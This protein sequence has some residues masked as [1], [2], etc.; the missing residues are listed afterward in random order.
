MVACRG[1]PPSHAGDSSSATN[2]PPAAPLTAAE[3]TALARDAWSVPEVTR[4][5]REAGL[6]VTDSGQPTRID[7]LRATG[8]LL[9][10]GRG[11]LA[12]FVYS[13]RGARSR[14][15]AG[16]D[17]TLHGLPTLDTPHYIESGNLIAVL[18]TPDDA[19]VERVTNALMARHAQGPP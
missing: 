18:H 17:T 8:H 10:V 14:D 5:L 2:A 3:S 7:G 16:L 1:A 19:T 4:R 11:T 6:V 13:G 9:H 15:G 12:V